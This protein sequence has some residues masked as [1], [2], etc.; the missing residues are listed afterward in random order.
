MRALLLLLIAFT[1]PSAAHA[2]DDQAIR[3]VQ[4]LGVSASLVVDAPLAPSAAIPGFVHAHGAQVDWQFEAEDLRSV[5][6]STDTPNHTIL[7]VQTALVMGRNDT[8]IYVPDTVMS[9]DQVLKFVAEVK[10]PR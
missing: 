8:F 7:V 1:L 3:T 5:H 10:R 4:A 6:R 9:Y 2:A